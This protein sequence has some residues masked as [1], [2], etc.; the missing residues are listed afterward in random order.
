MDENKLKAIVEEVVN[1]A[2]DPI[3]EQLSDPDT[4]LA[5]INRRL[6]ANT[7]AVVEVE[8]TLSGYA[9]AY[10]TNQANIERLDV[11]VSEL[12]ENAGIIPPPE[13]VIQR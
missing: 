10:K 12:E 5:A 11:R 8:S 4:G 9:D 3:K 6:D 13:L 2:V 7:A 1:R